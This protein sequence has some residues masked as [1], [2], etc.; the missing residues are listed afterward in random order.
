MDGLQRMSSRLGGS[1]LRP[2]SSRVPHGCTQCRHAHASSRPQ[3]PRERAAGLDSTGASACCSRGLSRFHN[4]ALCRKTHTSVPL[5]FPL[6]LILAWIFY[7]ECRKT[8]LLILA[9]PPPPSKC[10]LCT[11]DDFAACGLHPK[12][13]RG[14]CPWAPRTPLREALRRRRLIVRPLP[15]LSY[16][17]ALRSAYQ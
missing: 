17:L 6:T 1:G 13:L 4:A 16:G 12:W 10:V 9:D 11:Q 8:K 15:V 7:S 5:F 14:T 3:R 2:L